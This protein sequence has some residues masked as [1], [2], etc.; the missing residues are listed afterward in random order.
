MVPVSLQLKCMKNAPIS[1]IWKWF[2]NGL[3]LPCNL[4]VCINYSIHRT[5]LP[6]CLRALGLGFW[7][8][9]VNAIP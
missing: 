6:A 5:E 1:N 4:G 9:S 2:A 3:L 8:K 7:F